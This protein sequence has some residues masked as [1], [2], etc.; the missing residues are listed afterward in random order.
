MA[1][2]IGR[3]SLAVFF[4]AVAVFTNKSIAFLAF[5]V[6]AV[7]AGFTIAGIIAGSLGFAAHAL[8]AALAAEGPI[9]VG[10]I[11][12]TGSLG[13]AESALAVAGKAISSLV[14][15]I[16]DS[17][18]SYFG[19]ADAGIITEVGIHTVFV[20]FTRSA[21][22]SFIVIAAIA[23]TG[24]FGAVACSAVGVGLILQNTDTACGIGFAV[25]AAITAG[26]GG[27]QGEDTFIAF[28]GGHIAAAP[29]NTG[30]RAIFRVDTF[31]T[32]AC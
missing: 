30:R 15:T 17:T 8:E 23:V 6:V 3:A 9:A 2:G 20:T 24:S 12:A 21:A 7:A 28:A 25:Y 10:I 13:T 29:G 1:L 32:F 16:A 22:S 4:G 27:N 14:G 19:R 5:I 11:L 26:T 18:I 31:F